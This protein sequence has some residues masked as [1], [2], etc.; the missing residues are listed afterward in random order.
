MPGAGSRCGS[1][2]TAGSRLRGSASENRHGG[3]PRE[4]PVAPGQG[5]RASQA[6]PRLKSAPVGAPSTPHRG[7]ELLLS[8]R[9]L[10]PKP[11]RGSPADAK[12]KAHAKRRTNPGAATRAAGTNNTALFDIVNRDKANG[13]LCAPRLRTLVSRVSF[14]SAS[15]LCTRPGHET[16]ARGRARAHPA[17]TRSSGVRVLAPVMRAAYAAASTYRPAACRL[18][19]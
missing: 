4:V 13:S 6:R 10:A 19:K 9:P 1:G 5:G 15:P 3:A 18:R 8:R 12:A 11:P 14:R 17:S 2:S 7:T 16:D